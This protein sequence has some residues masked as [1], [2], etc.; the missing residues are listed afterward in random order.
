MLHIKDKKIMKIKCFIK[1]LR[2]PYQDRIEFYEVKTL[3]ET[4]HKDKYC[5]KKAKH[6]VEFNKA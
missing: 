3:D 2:Q 5:D 4:I 6:K 1:G